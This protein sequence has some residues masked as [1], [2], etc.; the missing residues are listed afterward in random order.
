L[1]G[2]DAGDGRAL[3]QPVA[4]NVAAVPPS[5]FLNGPAVVCISDDQ[6]T[7]TAWVIDGRSGTLIHTGPTDVRLI[8]G[9]LKAAQAGNYLVAAT[10]GEGLYGVGPNAETTW[11]QPGAGVVGDHSEDIAVEG[12][13]REGSATMFSLEDGEV[14]TPELP[15]STDFRTS[16]LF[17]GGFVGEFAPKTGSPFFQFFNLA[18]RL[19]NDGRVDAQYIGGTTGNVTALVEADGF[20]IYGPSGGKLLDVSG[21]APQG[22]QLIG[23]TL[24]VGERSIVDADQFQPYDLR[25]GD[26]GKPCGFDAVN[27]YVGTDGSVFVRAPWNLKSDDLAEAYDLATC[28]LVWSIPRPAGSLGRV[29]R[30]GDTLVQ[31]SDDGTELMSLVAPG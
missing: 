9:R 25:T 16:A 14:I 1:A 3:F 5:C 12:T 6:H 17:E 11:F 4:L 24:W 8:T 15:D 29:L 2:I 22:M 10:E 21:D 18:G 30:V 7:A 31:L 13:G 28:D 27:G 26:K 19:T 23:T 20:G